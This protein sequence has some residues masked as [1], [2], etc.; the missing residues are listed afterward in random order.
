M[1][2]NQKSEVL[3]FKKYNRKKRT[4]WTDRQVVCMH[5]NMTGG[6]F[7]HSVNR[8][9]KVYA[10]RPQSMVMWLVM[11]RRERSQGSLVIVK[12]IFISL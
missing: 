3:F 10:Q 8:P 1:I 11:Q 7:P 4:Q 6:S 5:H 2:N 9:W 12:D